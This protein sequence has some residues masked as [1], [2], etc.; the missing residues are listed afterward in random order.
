ML[1]F[2]G[3]HMHVVKYTILLY[4]VQERRR[5]RRDP[6]TTRWFSESPE[7]SFAAMRLIPSLIAAKSWRINVMQKE[8]GRKCDFCE[9]YGFFMKKMIVV[10]P[11]L[12]I[13]IIF[14]V[15]FEITRW[16]F[17]VRSSNFGV[18]RVYAG[19]FR[20]QKKILWKVGF[21]DFLAVSFPFFII[22]L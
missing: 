14:E 19:W 16:V 4:P 1:H 7:R 3:I 22:I 15:F 20:G 11:R 2:L 6:T 9:K 17:G 13:I 8:L 10:L 12:Q 18:R 21:L 5:R